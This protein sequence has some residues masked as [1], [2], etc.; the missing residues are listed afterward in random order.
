[1]RKKEIPG[2]DASLLLVDG[3][4]FDWVIDPKWNAF[5]ER[6]NAYNKQLKKSA[7]NKEEDQT[8]QESFWDDVA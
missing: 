3:E 1:M 7:R 5:I 2:L 8:G 4:V 6:R